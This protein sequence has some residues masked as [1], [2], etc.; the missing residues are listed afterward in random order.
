[1]ARPPA[2]SPS[3]SSSGAVGGRRVGGRAGPADVLA[4]HRRV[5]ALVGH[6]D[7]QVAVRRRGDRQLG[8][9]AQHELHQPVLEPDAG[10]A[11]RGALVAAVGDPLRLGHGV[12]RGGAEQR[13]PLR[14]QVVGRSSIG[15]SQS[16]S[17][18][19]SRVMRSEAATSWVDRRAVRGRVVGGGHA[20][21]IFVSGGWF[22]RLEGDLSSILCSWRTKRT[23]AR[24][25]P[26]VVAALREGAARGR[27]ADRRRPHRRGARLRPGRP[28]DRDGRRHRGRGGDGARRL[29][30]AWP[31]KGRTPIPPSRWH[32]RSR[33]PTRSDGARRA[34]AGRSTRSWPPT[35]SAPGSRGGRCP[36]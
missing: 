17:V 5:P 21:I 4:E 28:R 24:L 36:P 12:P 22:C 32:R 33:R 25:D 19:G 2:A 30:A 7:Q 20:T 8:Q 29:P 15:R 6:L 9:V 23:G 1:M 10:A 14:R 18:K 16:I 3:A 26:S 35:G 34:P 11:Q 31:P 13:E 27:Q